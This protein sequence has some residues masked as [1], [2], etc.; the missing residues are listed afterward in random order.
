M[1]KN[2]ILVVE[3]NAIIAMEIQERLKRIGYDVTGTAA[4]G[5]DA[6]SQAVADPPDLILMD[7]RLRGNMDGTQAAGTITSR[8]DVPVIYITAYSDSETRDRARQV[9]SYGYIIKPFN[10]QQLLCAIDMAF[11]NHALHRKVKE[12]EEKFRTLF[13]NISD[14]GFLYEL[15]GTGI[16]GRIVEVNAAALS[17]LGLSRDE[18]VGKEFAV[19]NDACC[20]R[21]FSEFSEQLIRDGHVRYEMILSGKDGRRPFVEIHTHIFSFHNRKTAISLAREIN[22]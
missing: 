17:L 4:T 2:R 22:S 6:I 14:A 3:D 12:S 5:D 8:V 20:Q 15:S 16:P 9:L 10:D 1:T 19:L 13:E 11:S 18:L 7:I 21:S